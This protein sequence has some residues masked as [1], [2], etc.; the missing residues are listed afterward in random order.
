MPHHPLRILF[1]CAENSCRSQMAEGFARSLGGGRVAA[2]SAGSRPAARVHPAAVRLMAER[3]ID[4][5]GSVPRGLDALAAGSTWDAVVTMGCGDA[6]PAIPARRRIDWDLPDPRDLPDDAFRAVRD[7]IERRVKILLAESA[8][9][10]PRAGAGSGSLPADGRRRPALFEEALSHVRAA[11]RRVPAERA[12]LIAI[13]GIDASGKGHVAG[14]LAA[15]LQE[16]GVRAIHLNIDGWLRLPHERFAAV[17][18]GEHFY[19]CAIR[20]DEMF[21]QLILPLRERRSIRLE[22]D[23]AEE[24]AADYRRHVYEFQEVEVILLEGIFLLKPAYRSSYDAAIWIECSFATA[25]E[26]ALARRQ[27]AL[28]DEDTVAAY[29]RVYFPAQEI[30]LARD[31]PRAAATLILDN[32]PRPA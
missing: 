8:R 32:D 26:R 15:A 24:T 16:E 13:S 5:G 23:F 29:R 10:P 30:H 2:A 19:R 25:L 4:L 18:P 27:E 1:V 9:M 20:F 6:C 11:R 3:G 14:G 12:A 28:S 22:A 17:N 31:D 21:S 7:E